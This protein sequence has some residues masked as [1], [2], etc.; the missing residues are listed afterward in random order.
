LRRA[1]IV[2]FGIRVG[3]EGVFNQLAGVEAAPPTLE[4]KL[5]AKAMQVGGLETIVL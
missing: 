1:T 4:M 3:F 5:D 2:V